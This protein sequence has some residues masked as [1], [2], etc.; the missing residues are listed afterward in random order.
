V[1]TLPPL[2]EALVQLGFER[3]NLLADSGLR[4]MQHLGGAAEA[5]DGGYC[6]KGPELIQRHNHLFPEVIGFM[7]KYHWQLYAPAPDNQPSI[8][9]KGG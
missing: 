8:H 7:K 5:L 3:L 1:G 6:L 9:F 2:E 4:N